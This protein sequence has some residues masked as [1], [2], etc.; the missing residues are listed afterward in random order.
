MKL[1]CAHFIIKLLSQTN[2]YKSTENNYISGCISDDFSRLEFHLSS[3]NYGRTTFKNSEH[4]KGYSYIT[5][6]SSP[7]FE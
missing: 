7:G 5:Y 2:I 6:V 1:L 4:F 3:P